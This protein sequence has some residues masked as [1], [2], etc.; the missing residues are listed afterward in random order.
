MWW[1]IEQMNRMNS[2]IENQQI[3]KMYGSF[4]KPHMAKSKCQRGKL[5][6]SSVEFSAL[7]TA[8]RDVRGD[9]ENFQLLG[10]QAACL[11]QLQPETGSHFLSTYRVFIMWAWQQN[12]LRKHHET[13][14][15]FM[16]AVYL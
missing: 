8:R 15:S 2:W 10:R 9:K 1:E 11:Y 5:Y 13:A 14:T 7:L 16:N 4:L 6:L 12:H 3:N